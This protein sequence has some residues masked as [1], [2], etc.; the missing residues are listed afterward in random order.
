MNSAIIE[1]VTQYFGLLYDTSTDFWNNKEQ[2]DLDTLVSGA[3]AVVLL[4]LVR[5]HLGLPVDG[6]AIFLFLFLTSLVVSVLSGLALM[7][8]KRFVAG[9]NQL[10]KKLILVILVGFILSCIVILADVPLP[11]I[12]IVWDG[13]NKVELFEEQANI[14]VGVVAACVAFLL[15]QVNSVWQTGNAD[16]KARSTLVWC[17]VECFI[18]TCGMSFALTEYPNLF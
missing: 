7:L 13:L 5:L 18:L 4:F 3:F 6:D 14:V 2:S 8:D 11:W 16:F 1:S 17:L 10:L 9:R 12:W 15:L